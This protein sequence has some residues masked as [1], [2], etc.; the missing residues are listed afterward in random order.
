VDATPDRTSVVVVAYDPAWP[1][2]YER[3]ATELRTLLP[4]RA[5]MHIG[6]TAVPGLAAKPVVDIALI[7]DDAADESTYLPVLTDVGFR[8]VVREPDWYEHR[9][10]QR[11][12]P[13]INLHVYPAG[14]EEVGRLVRF[15]DWLR[16]HDDDRDLYA[17]TKAELAARHWE[18][19]QE[20][21][22]AKSAVVAEIL[23]R[24]SGG[25]SPPISD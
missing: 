22:D 1:D 18:H 4:G 19:V 6:S 20:Y 3:V 17:R 11:D 15:R 8:L 16:I 10:F 13:A 25:P 5:V 7:L 14:C 24:A 12:A 21:A 9:M 2:T 23:N